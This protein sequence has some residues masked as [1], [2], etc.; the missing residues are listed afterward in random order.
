MDSSVSRPRHNYPFIISI[1]GA[2]LVCIQ[3]VLYLVVIATI[4]PSDP[5]YLAAL[6]LVIIGLAC[7]LAMFAGAYLGR[8]SNERKFP[9][10]LLGSSLLT[11]FLPYLTVISAVGGVLGSAVSTYILSKRRMQPTVKSA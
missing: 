3:Y 8:A 7:G 6:P 10:I 5:S 4:S 9:Y 11:L 2:G 1:L